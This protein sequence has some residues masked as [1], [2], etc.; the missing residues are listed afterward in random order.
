MYLLG[1]PGPTLSTPDFLAAAFRRFNRFYTPLI[2]TLDKGYLDTP[3][4][5][6]ES[7]VIY[8]V[9][10]RPGITA[11]EIRAR[12]GLD[13]GYLSRLIARLERHGLIERQRSETDGRAHHLHPTAEGRQ[14]FDLLDRRANTQAH[15]LF[16]HLDNT[17]RER[18]LKA[19]ATIETH[20]A[21]EKTQERPVQLREGQLGDLGWIFHRQAII[22]HQEFGYSDVFETYVSKGLPAFLTNKDPERDR[23]FIAE[24]SG[25][26]VGAV[27]IQHI[28]E[29]KGWAQ[30]R[31]YYVERSARGKGLGQRLL[32]TAIAFARTRQYK[33]ILLWTVSDLHAARHNYEK[34]GFSLAH[35]DEAPC[36]WAPWAH[37]QK[38]VLPL[39]EPRA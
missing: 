13:Q 31:W 32:G 8:E 14:A 3:F 17:E 18:L 27:A 16:D 11:K 29:P 20:L 37:E 21:Q 4:S 36:P 26:P 30:L 28:D 7:R 9:A 6:Q 22:Y 2:G 23:L 19:F 1:V 24:R 39:K 35:E 34:T 38:W 15:A 25:R 33:G 12:T 5:I 10:S